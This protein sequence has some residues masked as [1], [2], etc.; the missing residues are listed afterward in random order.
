[1]SGFSFASRAGTVS[2]VKSFGSSLAVNSRQAS[3][4]ATVAQY[5]AALRSVT[6]ANG[7]DNPSTANR[8]IRP[9]A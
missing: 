9:S 3:G 2:S 1:M 5:Q 7:S 6:Y 8:S 4:T